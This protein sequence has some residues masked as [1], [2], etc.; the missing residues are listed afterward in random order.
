MLPNLVGLEGRYDTSF[1]N[2]SFH[3]LVKN[4]WKNSFKK[5]NLFDVYFVK[6]K[7]CW[8]LKLKEEG[9]SI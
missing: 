2:F 3:P 4:R 1:Q 6:F 5:H 8:G 7:V 9:W